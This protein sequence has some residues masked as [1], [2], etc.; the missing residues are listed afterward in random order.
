MKKKTKLISLRAITLDKD[1]SAID[2]WKISKGTTIHVV[3]DS[4]PKH[5][6]LNYQLLVVRVDNGT[7][8]LTYM[9]E[10]VIRDTEIKQ[11]GNQ[12]KRTKR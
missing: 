9:P 11:H 2:G 7:G 8:D 10:A 4:L 3:N 12:N 6:T 5:P 1:I